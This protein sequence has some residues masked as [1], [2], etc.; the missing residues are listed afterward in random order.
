MK[1]HASGPNNSLWIAL[2]AN[3]LIPRSK[4]H[5]LYLQIFPSAASKYE[6]GQFFA[7]LPLCST[8]TLIVW[9]LTRAGHLLCTE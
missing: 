7:K 8:V 5:N 6:S 2:Q 3:S 4:N 9:L 1:P